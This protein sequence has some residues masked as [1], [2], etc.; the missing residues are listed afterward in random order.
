[1][2]HADFS[3][4]CVATHIGAISIVRRWICLR[5]SQVHV[6]CNIPLDVGSLHWA[7][8]SSYLALAQNLTTVCTKKCRCSTTETDPCIAPLSWFRGAAGLAPKKYSWWQLDLRISPFVC[9]LFG[10]VFVLMRNPNS[11]AKVHRIGLCAPC[12]VFLTALPRN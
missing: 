11:R 5:F 3:L 8:G 1:M 10:F 12:S 6:H 9:V 2:R 7:T 4:I